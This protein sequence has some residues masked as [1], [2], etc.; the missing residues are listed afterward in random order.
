MTAKQNKRLSLKRLQRQV[1]L[2]RKKE[3]AASRKLHAALSRMHQLGKVY[4]SK[5]ASKMKAM[6]SK[7]VADKAKVYVKVADD[8]KRQMQK[9]VSAHEKALEAVVANFD[10]KFAV[11]LTK[12][13]N[14][15][16]I[17]MK[18]RKVAKAAKK[19]GKRKVAKKAKTAKR[20]KKRAK[21]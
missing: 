18:K 21:K 8:V 11:N 16:A 6:R 3:Q 4:K 17:S 7:F 14:K 20:A 9:K 5:L 15:R 12:S 1:A 10:K 2:L 19:P 13:I